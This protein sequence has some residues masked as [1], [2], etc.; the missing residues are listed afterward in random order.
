MYKISPAWLEALSVVAATALATIALWKEWKDDGARRKSVDASI[1]ADAYAV[2]RTL[3]GWVATAHHL[4]AVGETPRR[5]VVGQQDKAVEE[6]L[7]RAIAAAPLA[8]RQVAA[9][10]REAYVLYYRAVEPIPDRDAGSTP[11][12][13]LEECVLRLGDAIEP[14]LKN[15]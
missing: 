12:R 6:R 10:I 9:A 3:R 1:S 7:A 11:M 8:S 13:N 5:L 2:Q 14:E 15:Q 4:A